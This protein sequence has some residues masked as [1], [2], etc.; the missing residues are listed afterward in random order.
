MDF[1]IV[2]AGLNFPRIVTLCPVSMHPVDIVVI[3]CMVEIGELAQGGAA[4]GQADIHVAEA[5][6]NFRRKPAPYGCSGTESDE[7]DDGVLSGPEGTEALHSDTGTDFRSR[8]KDFLIVDIAAC[9]GIHE[10]G[11]QITYP[12]MAGAGRIFVFGFEQALFHPI[13]CV[14]KDRCR[15][16]KVAGRDGPPCDTAVEHD[17]IHEKGRIRKNRNPLQGFPQAFPHVNRQIVPVHLLENG[18]L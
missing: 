1:D 9:N 15:I 14:F 17:C 13:F 2:A 6:G 7:E 3:H 8:G 10:G 12:H 4:F 18:I 5:V 11:I 16:L